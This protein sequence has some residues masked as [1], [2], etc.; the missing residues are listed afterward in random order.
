M[1][2]IPYTQAIDMWSFGCIMAELY[3]GI[4][5]FPGESEREQM[6]LLLEVLDVPSDEVIQM[7]PYAHKFFDKQGKPFIM[8]DIKGEKKVSGSKP[9]A[10]MIECDDRHFLNFLHHCL[11]WNPLKRYDPD[12]AL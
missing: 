3:S 2:G 4:P 10:D 12:Q 6:S 8:D 9:V 1:L 5:L 11:D 7:S